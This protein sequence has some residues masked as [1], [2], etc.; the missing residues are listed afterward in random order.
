MFRKRKKKILQRRT[1]GSLCNK[2][3]AFT[4]V[5]CMLMPNAS[6]VVNAEDPSTGPVATD[7]LDA[8]TAEAAQAPQSL[9]EEPEILKYE[10]SIN[11]GPPKWFHQ[12]SQ[13]LEYMEDSTDYTN[14][15]IKLRPDGQIFSSSKYE[16][17]GSFTLDLNDQEF[18]LNE[19]K[20]SSGT[21]RV[22]GG[23]QGKGMLKLSQET[24]GNS[25]NR[26]ILRVTENGHLLLDGV[27]LDSYAT[28]KQTGAYGIVC[29]GLGAVA[30]VNGTIN[31]YGYSCMVATGGG[32]LKVTG[33]TYSSSNRSPAIRLQAETLFGAPKSKV[34]LSGDINFDTTP[35]WPTI[36]MAGICLIYANDGGAT[37]VYFNPSKPLTF[38]TDFS[39]LHESDIELNFG[40][41]LVAG[42][43]NENVFSTEAAKLILGYEA[44]A[45]DT[46]PGDITIQKSPKT[47]DRIQAYIPKN[48]PIYRPGDF[49][50]PEYLEVTAYYLDDS[51]RKLDSSE[52]T[53]ISGVQEPIADDLWHVIGVE[54]TE[55]GI[56]KK[57][58]VDT[59]VTVR[60]TITFDTDGGTPSVI[61]SQTAESGTKPTIPPKVTKPGYEFVRWYDWDKGE[62]DPLT[63]RFTK[64]L[65]LK[66][67][68]KE[69]P[70]SSLEITSP[71]IE[72]VYNPGDYFGRKGLVVTATFSDG[73][74]KDVTGQ[75][76][77]DGE[78]RELKSSDEKIIIT[79]RGFNG[80]ITYPIR[81]VPRSKVTFDVD[82]GTG[83]Y[84]PQ[85]IRYKYYADKPSSNPTKNGYTFKYWYKEGETT[86]FDFENTPIIA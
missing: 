84:P 40:K 41:P 63:Y 79:Y 78:G 75:V 67:Q 31:S 58:F 24:D 66:A 17:R 49:F 35:D 85:E 36:H 37:P 70:V 45:P 14:S 6:I 81:V 56:T 18:Y 3:L 11:G 72:T 47:L 33:G 4:L 61:P 73:F 1:T 44:K 62:F 54:Y 20:I 60:R 32:I 46:Y 43:L 23:S 82:G 2:V 77:I 86:E 65:A 57:T 52:Y 51:Q 21:V 42:V 9:P 53:I 74:K 26:A 12:F 76:K 71:P 28:A 27:T 50:N 10:C 7:A 13:A 29:E 5:L 16:S 64:N 22:T 80:R 15:Y 68:W 8:K 59:E 38:S 34:Y 55:G 69:L 83:T 25:D 39:G 48:S 30:E 19:L